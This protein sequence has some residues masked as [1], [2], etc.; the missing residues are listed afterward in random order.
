MV[1]HTSR[2]QTE[3]EC[4]YHQKEGESLAIQYGVTT[5]RM[6]LLGIKFN[7]VTDHKPLVPLYNDS[8][9]PGPT[10]ATPTRLQL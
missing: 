10:S 2:A 4:R 7:V 5:N 8:K 3:V 9:R 1:N 6:Y